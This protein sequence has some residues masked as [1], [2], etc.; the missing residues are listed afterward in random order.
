MAVIVPRDAAP[1][2]TTTS[3]RTAGS[4]SLQAPA[5]LAIVD[6]LPRNA[7]G[8]VLKTR[9]REEHGAAEADTQA[10]ALGPADTPLLDETIGANFERT[11][12]TYPDAEA[13]VD[14]A[15]GRRWTYAELNA[16]IDL[17]ARALIASG[18]ER[19]DRVGI[20]APNCPEWT[21]LQYATAKIG[22]ILVAVNPPT[23][24]TSWPTCSVSRARDSWCQPA[25]SRRPTTAAWSAR[26]C[27][28][29]PM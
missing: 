5:A 19:G 11:A 28:K 21:I 4:T 27:R 2:P 24:P 29:H 10:Y 9:L 7:S 8:K 17:V 3:K 22:A 16:E 15:G 14:V 25:H 13:L 6:A 1:P 26:C 23:A 12:A 20:W 18:I